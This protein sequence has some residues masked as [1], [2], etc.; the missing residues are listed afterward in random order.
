MALPARE[1]VRSRTRRWLLPF[2]VSLSAT[3]FQADPG[4][5]PPALPLALRVA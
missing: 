4:A 3:P 2:L 1:P 5:P